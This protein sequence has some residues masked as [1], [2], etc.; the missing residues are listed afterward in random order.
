MRTASI[1]LMGKQFILI[2]IYLIS[3]T[4]VYSQTKFTQAQIDSMINIRWDFQSI[5]A[6]YPHNVSKIIEVIKRCCPHEI[7]TMTAIGTAYMEAEKWRDAATWFELIFK[8]TPDNLQVNYGYAICKREIGKSFFIESFGWWL[9]SQ[10]H[11]EYVIKVDST[12]RDVLYQYAFLEY[13]RNNYFKTIALLHRHLSINE[14]DDRAQI[15]IFRM[16]DR[17]LHN[18]SHNKVETW[19]KLRKTLYDIYYLGEF[20]RIKGRFEKADSIFQ[21][22]LADPDDFP[23]TPIYLSLVRLYVQ[24]DKPKDAEETYWRAVESVS[25]DLEARL[26]LEEFMYIVNESEYQFLQSDLPLYVLPDVLKKCWAQRDPMPAAPYNHRLIEHYRRLINAEENYRYDGYRHKIYKEIYEVVGDTTAVNILQF[27]EWYYE[28]YKLND[29]GLIYV[30][31]GEP[32]E[33]SFS[34]TKNGDRFDPRKYTEEILDEIPKNMSWFYYRRE[35]DPKF[36]FHFTVPK[37]S[38]VDYWTLVPGFTQKEIIASIHHWDVNLHRMNFER[39]IKERAK[40]VKLA[41]RT[42]RHTFPEKMKEL[43]M[44]HDAANFRQSEDTDLLQLSYAMPLVELIDDKSKKD[45][46]EF[47]A[48]IAIFDDRMD[49]LYKDLRNFTIKDTS[50]SHVFNDYFI[51]E[52]EFPLALHRHNIA[53][54]ARV[55]SANKLMSWQYHYTLTDSARNRLSCSTLKLAFEIS[56]TKDIESRHRSDLKIIPNPTKQFKKMEPLFAYFEIYNL[57]LDKEGMTNYTLN[58][59]LKEKT[60]KS[61]VFERIIGLF[62]GKR[63]YQVS[64]ENN[65]TGRTSTVAD[66]ISFDMSRLKA[67][68]YELNLM[69]K[70]QISGEETSTVAEF[71]LK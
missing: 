69:V 39:Y 57:L 46:V 8:H 60:Q 64:L 12:F 50:D 37:Y 26:L 65:M 5:R 47:E 70:D 63:G 27:P 71:K 4:S 18:K 24:T 54:H 17:I 7:D 38:P 14:F 62:G 29:Q 36:I 42:D 52:F 11:F 28:N 21:T 61:N 19:L 30:R 13:Y 3:S 48:G 45:S 33:W 67:G 56:L 22:L 34:L 20:Y 35:E 25:S 16:Y 23:V 53:I 66:Y 68:E 59:V 51:D 41:F 1:I 31:F 40:D 9:T 49:Q 44:Y 15:E 58:F 43:E 2:F 6:E 10:K 32:D 55:P